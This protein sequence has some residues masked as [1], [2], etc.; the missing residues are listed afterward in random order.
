MISTEEKYNRL[1]EAFLYWANISV[2]H[3]LL[4]H[5]RPWCHFQGSFE[6]C[7]NLRSGAFHISNNRTSQSSGA[8]VDW[9][10]H[11]G[12]VQP[13]RRTKPK[14]SKMESQDWTWCGNITKK[15]GKPMISWKWFQF[16]EKGQDCARRLNG[17]QRHQFW[18]GLHDSPRNLQHVLRI[19]TVMEIIF[20]ENYFR[21]ENFREIFQKTKCQG[22]YLK[23]RN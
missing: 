11:K 21:M 19:K 2:S 15:S 17:G 7:N 18:E 20:Y 8:L 22:D 4:R 5:F 14:S 16:K 9:L 6:M 12:R 23:N 13:L 1:T 3:L 10:S